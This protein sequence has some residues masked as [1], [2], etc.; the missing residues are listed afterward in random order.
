MDWAVKYMKSTSQER[1]EFTWHCRRQ[2]LAG[3][4]DAQPLTWRKCFEK[5]TV[6]PLPFTL[7]FS[8]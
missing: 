4:I 8:M 3:R 6:G 1:K 7:K 2:K 5:E